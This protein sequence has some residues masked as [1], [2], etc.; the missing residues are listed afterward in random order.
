MSI[1]VEVRTFFVTLKFI[2]KYKV[3]FELYS[4]IKITILLRKNRIN[5]YKIIKYVH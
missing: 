1:E 3:Y 5:M 4:F 2:K